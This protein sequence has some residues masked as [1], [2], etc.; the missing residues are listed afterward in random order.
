M[1]RK[2]HSYCH[3]KGSNRAYTTVNGQKIWLG[4]YGSDKSYVAYRRV[5]EEIAA[6]GKASDIVKAVEEPPR[7]P[8]IVELVAKFLDHAQRYHVKDGKPTSEVNLNARAMRFLVD[9][10]GELLA[11]EF[12]PLMLERVRNDIVAAG[13]ARNTVNAHVFR[14]RKLFKWAASRELV[15]VEVFQR[16]CTLPAL[17]KGRTEAPDHPPVEPVDTEIVERTLPHLTPVVRDLVGFQLATG[18]RPSE[19]CQVRPCDITLG[20][21]G[22]WTY[23]PASHKTEHHGKD[24]KIYLGPR[25]QEIIRPYLERDPEIPC[26]SPRESERQRLA[27]AR[28]ARKSKLTPS[29]LTRRPKRRPKRRPGIAYDVGSYRRAIT[30]ACKLAGVEPAWS[31][32]QLRHAAATALRARYGLEA[33]KLILGHSDLETS[34]MY[35]ERDEQA[36]RRIARE[37]C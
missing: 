6:K 9:R 1:A 14:I 33:A 11:S 31:P 12:G 32:N 8:L 19:A 29:Q 37:S 5:L 34:A 23:T 7:E 4:P 36:A 17:R 27:A 16:L 24:R 15:G 26:F 28:R 25:A 2:T 20:T 30:R 13:L 18:C 3:H 22:V 21:D 10:A 35:A